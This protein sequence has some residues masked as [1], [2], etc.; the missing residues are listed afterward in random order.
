L[1]GNTDYDRAYL[2]ALCSWKTF[3]HSSEPQKNFAQR[4]AVIGRDKGINAAAEA[5]AEDC[6]QHGLEMS[7]ERVLKSLAFALD[8]Y[9]EQLSRLASIEDFQVEEIGKL[10]PGVAG[11]SEGERT[12]RSRTPWGCLL[13]I[14]IALAVVGW[15]IF[16]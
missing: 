11:L 1:V 12:Q 15:L 9:R 8:R 5:I 13:F 4:M 3:G 7:A 6:R 14:V 10:P 2:M 16:R